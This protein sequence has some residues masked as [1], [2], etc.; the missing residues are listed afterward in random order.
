V[1]AITTRGWCPNLFAPMPTGDGWLARIR[2]PRATLSFHAARTLAEAA[3]RFGNGIISVTN[4]GNLQVRGLAGGSIASFADVI[5]AAGL[6]DADPVTEQRRAVI[7]PPLADDEAAAVAIA[8]EEMLSRD[9][10]LAALPEKFCVAIDAAEVLPLGDTGADLTVICAGRAGRILP[11][12]SALAIEAPH[13][14]VAEAVLRLALTFL[15]LAPQC[16][17]PARRMVDLIS[18]IGAGTLFA[19][20]GLAAAVPATLAVPM[21]T[22]G[23]LA[24]ATR[25]LG[26]FNIGLPFGTITASTLLSVVDVARQYGDATLHTTPWRAFLLPA[27]AECDVPAL[28]A[29]AERLGLVVDPADPRRAIIA[30]TGRPGCAAASVDLHTDVTLLLPLAVAGPVHLSGCAK[31]CAL[32]H[33]APITLVG[34]SGRYGIVRNGRARDAPSLR[35]LTMEQVAAVLKAWT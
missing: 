4:R 8:I 3:A 1:S 25:P 15:E 7:F 24:C 29:A 23:W 28:Q 32:P 6:A 10:R 11:R 16:T 26:S 14:E 30:C 35:G 22:V 17:P 13:D 12:G 19:A 18:T 2:P 5:V 27:I 34:D 21:R 20:A 31:G 9:P 33:A